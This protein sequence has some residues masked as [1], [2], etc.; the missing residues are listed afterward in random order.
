[1]R[2]YISFLF[3]FLSLTVF[4][5][6]YSVSGYL[7]DASTGEGLVGATVS[8]K[9]TS[10]GVSTNVYGFYSLTLDKGK[11]TLLINY[12]GFASQEKQIDLN[13]NTTI[14]LDLAESNVELKEVVVSSEREDA[15]V[16]SIQMSVNKI[17]IKDIKKIPQFLGEA[18]VIKS[19]QLLPGVSTVGEGASGFN[20][21]GG[22]ADQN[23]ILLDEAPVFNSSHVFGFFS[24][25]NPDAVKDVKLI[26]GGIPAQYGGRA[27]SILDVRMKEGNNKR[28]AVNGGVGTLFSRLSIEAPIIKDKASFIVAGRRSYFDVFFPFAK[29]EA[30][31]DAKVY[32]Y[33][34]TAKVNY[35]ISDKDRVFLSSYFGQDVFSQGTK[36]GFGFDYGNATATARWNHIFSSKVFSNITAVYSKYNYGLG[37]GDIEKDG[38]EWKSNIINYTLKPELIYYLNSK[39]TVTFGGQFTYYNF[40]PGTLKFASAGATSTIT[41]KDKFA[42]ENGVYLANEQTLN[43]KWSVQYGLRYSLYNYLGKGTQYNFNDTIPG[44][45]KALLSEK[46]FGD[47]K[48]MQQYGF[49]EPRFAIKYEVN[50]SS[51]VKASYNRMSQYIHLISNTA[52]NTPLDVWNPTT[53][54]IKPQLVDQGAMG[55]FKNFGKSNMYESSVEVFYKYMQ[56]QIDYIDG[57]NLLLNDLLEA[58]LLNGIG[59]AYGAEFYLKK[60]KGLFTGWI[61]YTAS[62]SERKVNGINEGN[63]YATRFDKLHNVSVV[64]M[65]DITDQLSASAN[66]VYGSGTP[67][68]FPTNRVE[69]QGYIIPY[70]TDNTRN[71]YRIPAYHRLDLAATYT[72]KKKKVDQNFE[73]S[74]VVSVYNVYN[75]RNPFSVYFRTNPANPQ[76]TEAVRFAVLGSFVPAVAYN[77]KF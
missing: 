52:A 29:N 28:V 59:R 49:F 46:E 14:T 16:K 73:H 4:A 41:A 67:T 42:N 22:A 55:I 64:A 38:F 40:V 51:S 12:I 6:K 30:V 68:T 61:S 36:D 63:W 5:Q 75:R 11:Y 25:F 20:V 76:Q 7:K 65:Y 24:V 71:N 15:N 69:I 10:N 45:R 47:N 57:A 13:A 74:L 1:M 66:F 62:R 44:L 31:Q 77:F 19:V 23:L 9:G 37:V 21:R 2:Y 50:E 32:F 27:S 54:N 34:L 26:K 17:D 53:N 39:N 18:D 3:L 70:N 48:L 35:T 33:D 72:F 56:N 8:V 58:E 60:A 43:Q